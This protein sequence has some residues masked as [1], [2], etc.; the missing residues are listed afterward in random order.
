MNMAAIKKR[1]A[2]L[3][4]TTPEQD[5]VGPALDCLTLPEIEFIEEAK[6]LSDCG[7]Q[8]S[9]IQGLMGDRWELLQETMKKFNDEYDRLVLQ[10]RKPKEK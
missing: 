6:S 5:L 2:K 7:H 10:S 4:S 9:D 8:E 1:V 3:E